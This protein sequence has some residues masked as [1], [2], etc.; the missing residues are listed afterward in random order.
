MH[1]I[2]VVCGSVHEGTDSTAAIVALGGLCGVFVT[3]VDGMLGTTQRAK[4]LVC[5]L[6]FI[7]WKGC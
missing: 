3:A 4:M 1:S 5:A 7:A 2:G 6:F